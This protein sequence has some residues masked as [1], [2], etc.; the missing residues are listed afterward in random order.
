MI[1]EK[2]ITLSYHLLAIEVIK[3]LASFQE[4]PLMMYHFKKHYHAN[5]LALSSSNQLIM[6]QV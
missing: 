4:T 3:F 2:E 6:I 5:K 1:D